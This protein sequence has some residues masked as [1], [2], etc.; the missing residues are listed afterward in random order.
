MDDYHNSLLVFEKHSG[1]GDFTHPSLAVDILYIENPPRANS[2]PNMSHEMIVN[3]K[4]H[5]RQNHE[6]KFK[7]THLVFM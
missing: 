3:S 1:W 6:V 2:I 7:F 5:L 4:D